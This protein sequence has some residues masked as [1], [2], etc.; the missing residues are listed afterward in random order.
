MKENE[1]FDTNGESADQ[2]QADKVLR[3]FDDIMIL[4]RSKTGHDFSSYKK[5]TVYR[6]TER[7]TSIHQI[8]AGN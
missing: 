8:K 1:H 2:D 5:N 4:L 7:R 3:S 6:R